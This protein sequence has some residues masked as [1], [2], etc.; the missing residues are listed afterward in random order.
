MSNLHDEIIVLKERWREV[1]EMIRLVK[2]KKTPPHKK[3]IYLKA[4]FLML[5][6]HFEGGFYGVLRG[7]LNDI[8]DASDFTC[9]PKTL[10][11]AYVQYT[12][13]ANPDAKTQQVDKITAELHGQEVNL[14]IKDDFL[15]HSSNLTPDTVRQ[16]CQYFNVA[17]ITKTLYNSDFEIVFQNSFEESE[18]FIKKEAAY[19]SRMTIAFPYRINENRHEIKRTN[20]SS[21]FTEFLNALIKNRNDAVHGGLMNDTN[22]TLQELENDL[23]KIQSLTL[24]EIY[25]IGSEI[26]NDYKKQCEKQE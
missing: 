5:C 24:A 15:N 10:I 25:C 20:E 9:L 3:Q 18:K 1:S 4:G 6:S 17:D 13:F 19:L 14:Q 16:C 11:R 22:L 12:L 23:F 8:N 2:N 21:L 26:Q 7:I